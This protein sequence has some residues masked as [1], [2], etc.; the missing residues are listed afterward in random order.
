MPQERLGKDVVHRTKIMNKWRARKWRAKR[1]I[2][3]S[4]PFSI[5]WA[6]QQSRALQ[7]LSEI[8]TYFDN[9]R[10]QEIANS[11]NLGVKI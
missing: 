6:L 5:L 11:F 8:D 10:D 9:L 3:Q 1:R 4:D 7:Y 2:R